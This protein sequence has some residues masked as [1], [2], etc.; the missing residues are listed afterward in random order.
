[1]TDV[2]SL[3]SPNELLEESRREGQKFQK[4]RNQKQFKT[5]CLKETKM[6]EL[7]ADKPHIKNTF[8]NFDLQLQSTEI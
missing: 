1:M 6:L 8:Q 5:C 4:E 3:Y 7:N 2:S